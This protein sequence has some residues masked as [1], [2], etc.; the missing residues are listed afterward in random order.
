LASQ[1]G[2]FTAAPARAQTGQHL[3][4]GPA[5][6]QQRYERVRVQCVGDQVTDG[7]RVFARVGVIGATAPWSYLASSGQ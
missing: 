7:C 5:A 6:Q 2:V 4:A 3:A 1:R